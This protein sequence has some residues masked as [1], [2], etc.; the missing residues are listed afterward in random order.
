MKDA[1]H[2]DVQLYGGPLDGH[3]V[4]V[5]MLPP[6]HDVYLFRAPDPAGGF[7]IWA[8]QWANKTT[9]G[10]KRWVLNFLF[11]VAHQGGAAKS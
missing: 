10:G 7:L 3:E 2:I 6:G 5:R 9:A 11:N 8:Y 1:T 4:E